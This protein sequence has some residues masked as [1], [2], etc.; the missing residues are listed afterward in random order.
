[1]ADE[2]PKSGDEIPTLRFTSKKVDDSWK[3]EARREKEAAARAAGSG[4]APSRPAEQ[5]RQQSAPQPP[6]KQPQAAPASSDDAK[7][8]QKQLSPQEQQQSKIFMNF[9]AGLAQQALMQL[10]EIESPFTGQRELDLNGARYTIELLAVIQQR[11]KG[12]LV[13]EE[14]QLLEETIADLKMRYVE[15]AQ[16]LQRQMAAQMAKGGGGPGSPGGAPGGRR[17]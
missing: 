5:P 7:A 6:G 3:E 8:D 14:P 17:K 11:T 15:L 2:T 1:M 9:L 12:N 10:G 13:G 16:E 4:A